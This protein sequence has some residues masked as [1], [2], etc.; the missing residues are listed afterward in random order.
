MRDMEDTVRALSEMDEWS[1]HRLSISLVD[2]F[3]QSVHLFTVLEMGAT[4]LSALMKAADNRQ[5]DLPFAPTADERP[6]WAVKI[7]VVE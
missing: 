4:G 2:P 1:Y 7:S 6:K 5:I 3:G